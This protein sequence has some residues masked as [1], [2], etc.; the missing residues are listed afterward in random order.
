ME[1]PEWRVFMFRKR[2]LERSI[3]P[4]LDARVDMV[5]SLGA[6]D[7]P[8]VACPTARTSPTRWARR[9]IYVRQEGETN[10][11]VRDEMVRLVLA[12][13]QAAASP[14]W[15]RATR[16]VQLPSAGRRAGSAG[17]G[18]QSEPTAAPAP[19]TL[20]AEPG[21]G[22]LPLPSI[23]VEIVRHRGAQ[24]RSLLHHPRSA[25]RQHG[26]ERHAGVGAQA[27]EL[28]HHP[29]PDQRRWIRPA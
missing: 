4:H 24:G 1:N 5:Q 25:Q 6:A 23:G 18:R 20:P 15:R 8:R 2:E 19:V 3:T 27:V 7:R 22:G 16:P 12:G 29:A 26:A 17:L 13:R 9:A 11:A 28:R 14:R 10:E 21:R